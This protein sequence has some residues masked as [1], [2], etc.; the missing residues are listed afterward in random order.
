MIQARDATFDIDVENIATL[1]ENFQKL[2]MEFDY[3]FSEAKHVAN[4]LEIEV[5][6]DCKQRKRKKFFNENQT[7]K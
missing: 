1:I 2:R 7:V 5:K 3:V 6:L 4:A